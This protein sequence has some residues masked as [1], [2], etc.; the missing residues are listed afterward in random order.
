MQMR[1][2]FAPIRAVVKDEPETR[3]GKTQLAREFTGFKQEV[4]QQ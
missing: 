3:F 1:H 2:G 4:P